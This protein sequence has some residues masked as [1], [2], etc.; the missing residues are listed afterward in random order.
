MSPVRLKW[1]LVL[2]TPTLEYVEK[3]RGEAYSRPE[4][5]PRAADFSFF[6]E[7]PQADDLKHL[8][9]VHKGPGNLQKHRISHHVNTVGQHQLLTWGRGGA[10]IM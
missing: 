6:V 1:G 3:N 2:T 10:Q 9:H 4:D 8:H 5:K 7:V